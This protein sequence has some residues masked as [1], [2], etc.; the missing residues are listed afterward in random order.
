[1][2]EEV[3]RPYKI[4]VKYCDIEGIEKEE[5]FEGFEATVLC[6][7]IDH[8]DELEPELSKEKIQSAIA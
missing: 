1:M 2:E 5:Y 8:L 4:K 3:K 6:H 7:E